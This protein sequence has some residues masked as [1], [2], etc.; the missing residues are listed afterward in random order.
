M[1]PCAFKMDSNAYTRTIQFTVKLASGSIPSHT[2]QQK[3]Q[4]SACTSASASIP[5][6]TSACLLPGQPQQSCSA[7]GRQ[8]F[9]ALK[10]KARPSP[11]ND[12]SCFL[13][14]VYETQPSSR[15]FS[16]NPS[17]TLCVQPLLQFLNPSTQTNLTSWTQGRLLQSP[18]NTLNPTPLHPAL[19][20]A[21]GSP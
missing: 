19:E 20:R 4:I 17:T 5:S 12:G 7:A 10:A 1:K 16:Q 13:C 8:T 11:Q 2:S 14:R 6:H 9:A 3:M 15:F 18:A 21:S